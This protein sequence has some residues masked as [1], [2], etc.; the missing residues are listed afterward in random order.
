[1]S[2]SID[3][4]SNRRVLEHNSLEEMLALLG[5]LPIFVDEEEYVLTG[6]SSGCLFVHSSV[7][8]AFSGI[9]SEFTSSSLAWLGVAPPSVQVFG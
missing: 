3:F 4:R 1:M 5:D 2:W 6:D 8:L 7:N 9:S